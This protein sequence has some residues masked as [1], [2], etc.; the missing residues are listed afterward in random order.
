MSFN[1]RVV[2]LAEVARAV[3][4]AVGAHGVAI[5]V[6]ES[7]VAADASYAHHPAFSAADRAE[8]V[9]ALRQLAADIEKAKTAPRPTEV[10]PAGAAIAGSGLAVALAAMHAKCAH[11]RLKWLPLA[12]AQVCADCGTIVGGGRRPAPNRGERW[13][14]LHSADVWTVV[15]VRTDSLGAYMVKLERAP[16]EDELEPTDREV[17]RDRFE[18][19]WEPA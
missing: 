4:T 8:L 19:D 13:R 16:A 10:H 6:V 1:P 5:V 12:D 11:T 18:V 7:G 2:R 17:H 3:G 15:S 9:S 14:M